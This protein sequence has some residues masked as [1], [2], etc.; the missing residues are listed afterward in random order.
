L[1]VSDAFNLPI[2]SQIT[3]D[4]IHLDSVLHHIISNT[5]SESNHLTEKLLANL[6]SKLSSS[7]GIL[8]VEEMFYNSFII[9]D[10]TSKIV[11]YG[12]KFFNYLKVDLHKLI[13][14]VYLGLEVN[15]FSE[16]ELLGMLS[17]LGEVTTIRRAETKKTMLAKILFLKSW[18]HVSYIIRPSNQL[19]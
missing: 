12:L 16:R 19:R 11:F 1:S 7:N 9:S 13:K 6:S 3:F 15:F 18:G 10:L 17:R 5:K 2:R 14:E 4:V 8:L